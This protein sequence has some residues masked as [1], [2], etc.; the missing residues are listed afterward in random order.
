[1]VYTAIIDERTR[2]RVFCLRNVQRMSVREVS[3]LLHVSRSSVWRIGRET[4]EAK[5]KALLKRGRPSKLTD[6]A[7]R[8]ILRCFSKIRESEGTFCVKRLMQQSGIGE[9]DVTPRTINRFLNDNGYRYLQARKKGLITR[10]D[11]KD[12]VAFATA[13][14]HE[15][16][17]N[18]WTDQVAFYLDGTGFVFKTNPLDQARAPR[19]RVWRKPSEGLCFGCTAKGKKEGTG[20][21]VLKLMVAISYNKG[22]IVCQPFEKMLGSYFARF[23]TERFNSMFEKAGEGESRLWVQDGDP[24]QNSGIAKAAMERVNATLF[25]IPASPDLNPIENFLNIVSNRL[26]DSAIDKHI[27]KETYEQ[28][29]ER[30]L[31]TV[32]SIPIKTIDNLIGSMDS[33]I[34]D[35]INAN[36][37]RINY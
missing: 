13:V 15:R 9:R 18:F 20:G 25:K 31:N 6:R 11:L 24:C 10:K 21:K 8:H 30:V 34:K 37:Q 29:Q 4:V 22:V 36:G 35:V 19:A 2:A 26:R 16:P 14:L 23:V 3:R 33:R 12:R 1:M 7:K 5:K 28:F 32:Y 27:T 17:T